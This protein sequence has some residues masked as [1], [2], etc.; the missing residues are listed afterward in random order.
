[1]T[2]PLPV[3]ISR[4]E[5]LGRL[6]APARW[7]YR[8]GEHV[9]ILGPTGSG[10]TQLAYELLSVTARPTLPAVVMVP[11]PKDDTVTTWAPV[12]GLK[13]VR[14][15]PPVA[16]PFRAQPPGWVVWPK[17]TFDEDK[18]DEHMSALFRNTIRDSYKRGR[19]ILFADEVALLTEDL[20]LGRTLSSVWRG[21][22]SMGTG[23]WAASQRPAYIPRLAYSMAEHLFLADDPDLQTRKRYA[24]IGGVNPKAVA[25]VLA[26]LPKFSFLYFRRTG[27][28]WCVVD[29]GGQDG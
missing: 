22:R 3:T 13:T 14:Q 17:F 6:N 7:S 12:M 19:R 25:E 10:K 26:G 1:V 18:D 27:R 15:W 9:T 24:E 20:N 5:F 2:H 4:D 23:V 11:K 21:G 28:R 16:R 8:A 29:G